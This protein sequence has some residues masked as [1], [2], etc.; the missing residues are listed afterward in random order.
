MR[1]DWQ[2]TQAR[3]V[4]QRTSEVHPEFEDRVSKLVKLVSR[5]DRVFDARR[6]R[7]PVEPEVGPA[8][9][10]NDLPPAA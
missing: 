10:P 7:S 8:V 3:K 6:P 2:V 1:L 9:G 4:L 5:R